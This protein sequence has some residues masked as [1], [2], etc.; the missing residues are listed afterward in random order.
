MFSPVR[1][2][3]V[4]SNIALNPS[5]FCHFVFLILRDVRIFSGKPGESTEDKYLFSEY[6][7]D[8]LKVFRGI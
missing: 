4:Y 1:K 5:L 7:M 8:N 6:Y 3:T 2:L